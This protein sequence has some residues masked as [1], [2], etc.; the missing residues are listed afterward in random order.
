MENL[1]KNYQ[2]YGPDLENL[3]KQNVIRF[4]I[5]IFYQDLEES[6]QNR[7]LCGQID[8]YFANVQRIQK[9]KM[10]FDEVLEESIGDFEMIRAIY[11]NQIGNLT[12]TAYEAMNF[13]DEEKVQ[14]ND[15]FVYIQT[16]EIISKHRGKGIGIYNLEKALKN[17]VKHLNLS[18]FVIIPHPLQDVKV[19]DG[20]IICSTEWNELMGY[21]KLENNRDI[22]LE[23]LRN[24]YRKIG[25]NLIEGTNLMVCRAD[26][27]HET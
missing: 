22:A 16:L 14:G 15:N 19:F 11:D 20:K 6:E 25:F 18:F 8:W 13:T 9:E 23:K 12:R 5:E 7:E 17:M 1:L 10:N 24:L 26:I 27:F 21:D 2:M 3:P 4:K